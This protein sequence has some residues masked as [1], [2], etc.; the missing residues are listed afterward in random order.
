LPNISYQRQGPLTFPWPFVLQFLYLFAICQRLVS[1]LSTSVAN[2]FINFCAKLQRCNGGFYRR[3]LGGRQTV[4][5]SRKVAVGTVS[6]GLRGPRTRGPGDSKDEDGHWSR[7]NFATL[8][9]HYLKRIFY[10]YPFAQIN[11]LLRKLQKSATNW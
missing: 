11:I 5:C 10:Y 6:S 7:D 1:Y 8:A 3:Q 9:Q 2:N 4:N